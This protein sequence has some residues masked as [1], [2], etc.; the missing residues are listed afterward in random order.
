MSLEIENVGNLHIQLSGFLKEEVKRMEQF[1][2]RQKEQR[3]K[4]PLASASSFF[5]LRAILKVAVMIDFVYCLYY[6]VVRSPHGEG[7]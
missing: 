5:C 4:V 7:P 1:K 3:K 2:E 6:F